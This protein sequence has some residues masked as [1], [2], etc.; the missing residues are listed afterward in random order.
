MS[1][2]CSITAAAT[3]LVAAVT[4]VA[5]AG[6]GSDQHVA[7]A[8]GSQRISFDASSCAPQW[9]A[10]TPGIYEFAV[11][12]R[13]DRSASVALVNFGSGTIVAR[14]TDAAPDR[15][16]RL[17]ARLLAGG[18]YQWSCDLR[19]LAPRLSA[20]AQVRA[21]VAFHDSAP[22]V[23][24]PV[25][26][27]QL[28]G[29]LS[30]YRLYVDRRL[31]RIRSQIAAM[32][33]EIAAGDLAGARS[34][35]LTAHLTWLTVGQDDGAYGAFGELGRRIDGT[36]AGLVGGTAS[37][38]FTGFHK[39][40]LDLFPQ[41]DLAAAGHDSTVLARLIASITPAAVAHTYLPATTASINAWTLRC[42]EILEDALRD[43]LTG[44]DNYG[45]NSDLASVDADIS[46]DREMLKL[47]APL[48]TPRA[49]RL[50]ATSGRQLTE[51][52][53]AVTAA[54]GHGASE[55]M[56]ALPRRLRQQVDAATGTALETLAPVS[57]LM[58]VGNS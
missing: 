27:I 34:A 11:D 25:A 15:I 16:G 49:R 30:Y 35:W 40:E 9:S 24:A 7:A 20:T 2:W 45:S 47:L 6:C 22:P 29:P 31:A 43:S 13:S 18:A 1:A 14:L 19:G 41:H 32:R 46:A 51:L 52:R 37:P 36:A 4:A 55:P 57:E 8:Q 54:G 44:N 10:Q 38:A 56:S 42:H 53:Q 26:T 5:L 48:I 23:P 39:I 58:Q 17:R 33:S 50:V 3:M 21:P 28:V 12:N